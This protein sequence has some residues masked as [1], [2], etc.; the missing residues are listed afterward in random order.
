MLL[1]SQGLKKEGPRTLRRALPEDAPGRIAHV[2][3]VFRDEAGPHF[4][5]E[6]VVLLPAL[7]GRSEVLRR[8]S[9]EIVAEH[10]AI[11]AMVA[12]LESATDPEEALDALGSA[13]EAHVRKEERV[14]FEEMQAVLSEAELRELGAKLRAGAD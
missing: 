1:L 2:R 8:V 9:E 11:E 3:R 7:R 14:L 13:L 10:R 4:A 6:E 5:E 12:G